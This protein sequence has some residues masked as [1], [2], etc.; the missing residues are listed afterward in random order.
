VGE[1]QIAAHRIDFLAMGR[2][3]LADPHLPNKLKEDRAADI[4]PC[5]YCYTC[6][7]A[8][9]TCEPVRCAINPRTGFEY[10]A[11]DR[12]PARRR[13]IAV[14]G[15]GPA[16]METAR[17]L[18]ERGHEVILFEQGRRLGGT[19]QFAALA[20]EPNER[21]LKWLRRQIEHSKVDVRLQT[22]VTPDLIRSLQVDAVV[23]AS[24]ARRTMPPLP[25]SDLPHV[26]SGDEMRA[27]MLGTDGGEQLRHKIDWPTRVLTRIGAATGITANLPLVRQ[28]TQWWLPLA[29]RIVIVGGE[30]VG[31]ELAEFLTLRGRDVTVV[32]DVP[33][34]G[35]GL[36][37]VRRMRLLAELREHD[38]ALHADAR[39]I[40]IERDAVVFTDAAGARQRVEAGQVIVAKGAQGDSQLADA[41]G[42]YK[43]PVYSIGDCTGVG[44]IEGAMR[45][46][47]KI[48]DQIDAA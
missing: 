18:S 37:I 17:R 27:L 34:L 25:G 10:L 30:L 35:A 46:A 45:G 41:L 4:L 6:I 7:S 1:A 5:I 20:Y 13:R 38:V 42:A 29:Q 43:V 16:G 8:I 12:A 24:G 31:L 44:Y 3:L 19:L 40:A 36:T 33:R 48:A 28:V 21:L 26:F 39:D 14:I 32:D 11:T 9:Y 47:A 15:G 2:K 23:I 22:T